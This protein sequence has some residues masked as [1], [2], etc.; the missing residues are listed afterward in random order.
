MRSPSSGLV[1]VFLLLLLS[2]AA[3]TPASAQVQIINS[4]F[5]GTVSF[6]Y[7][8]QFQTSD[9]NTYVYTCQ[10]TGVA[11]G[12]SVSSS[13]LLSGTPTQAGNYNFSVKATDASNPD[14]TSGFVPMSIQIGAQ[15]VTINTNSV[16]DAVRG[17]AYN[18]PLSASGGTGTYSWTLSS[19]ALPDGLSIVPTGAISVYRRGQLQH[20]TL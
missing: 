16:P 4:P 14:R 18:T 5:P 3:V 20:Q 10:C 17:V 7:S 15:P 12:L 19:G 9:Q 8:F 6:P 11:P 13:G 2:A 1:V